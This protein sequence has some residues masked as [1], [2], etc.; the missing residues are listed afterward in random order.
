MLTLHKALN[1]LIRNIAEFFVLLLLVRF[2]LQAA[3][4]SFR[5]PLAHFVLALTNWIVLPLRRIIPAA[6]RFDTTSFVL[7]LVCAFL[8]HIL[9]LLITPWPF[10]LTSP[11]SLAA[12]LLA[13]FVELVKMSLYLL[14]AAIIG[15]ALMSWLSPINPLMPILNALTTPFLRPLRRFIPP[16]GGIDITPLVVVLLI[17]LVLNVLIGQLEILILQRV[18]IAA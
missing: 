3:R 15:Q 17:Q 1:F 5:H 6:G 10:I 9:L 11:L 18:L 7:A 8:M 14:F 12:L 16:I 2:Y 4:V 13:A